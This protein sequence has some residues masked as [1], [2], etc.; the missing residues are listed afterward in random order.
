L[1]STR[2]L[3]I[4]SPKNYPLSFLR[5]FDEFEIKEPLDLKSIYEKQFAANKN[6][7]IEYEK[8][9]HPFTSMIPYLDIPLFPLIEHHSPGNLMFLY[10]H[11]LLENSLLVL[12][13]HPNLGILFIESIKNLL[14]PF[15][16][17]HV[18]IPVVSLRLIH[19]LQ[20]PM[21]FL[22]AMTCPKL[23]TLMDI[24]QEKE[25]DLS[26]QCVILDL[27]NDT[28]YDHK[29][30]KI[31]PLSNST[32]V[33]ANELHM[34]L[35]FMEPKM[36]SILQR[37][38]ANVSVA[39]EAAKN[40]E[41]AQHDSNL[42]K[43]E[44]KCLR[45]NSIRIGRRLRTLI[46]DNS[47][48]VLSYSSPW[49]SVFGLNREIQF[50]FISLLST[51]FQDFEYYLMP[52]ALM[53]NS[54]ENNEHSNGTADNGPGDGTSSEVK[55]T[56]MQDFFD[57]RRY[58]ES[59][60]IF[61]PH[62]PYLSFLQSFYKTQLFH[63]FIQKCEGSFLNK[64]FEDSIFRK[65]CRANVVDYL[66]S[67]VKRFYMPYS[68]KLFKRGQLR[69]NWKSREFV[70]DSGSFVL[71]Y[72]SS[73]GH[74]KGTLSLESDNIGNLAMVAMHNIDSSAPTQYGIEITTLRL[75]KN[76]KLYC[77]TETR[78]MQKMWFE[79][80]QSRAFLSNN[81]FIKL[82]NFYS[83]SVNPSHTVEHTSIYRSRP[84]SDNLSNIASFVSG[85]MGKMLDDVF[86]INRS[87]NSKQLYW[88][89]MLRKLLRQNIDVSSP[90]DKKA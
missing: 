57:I 55:Q 37:G 54:N 80:I 74:L 26:D 13:P 16:W 21:P 6:I 2:S 70:L 34:F 81:Q 85:E 66:S 63:V 27:I 86:N 23:Q 39:K 40:S 7:D 29:F 22:M 25:I 50:I 41:L 28:I 56:S 38:K 36:K 35:E 62:F 49:S 60:H 14:F 64:T 43:T 68:A 69:K 77:C 48:I 42:G 1:N 53:K 45:Q 59:S 88:E 58:L 52:N 31:D 4:L 32:P 30:S 84:K 12:C 47:E 10:R 82:C 46:R 67:I 71:K 19:F 8:E 89:N 3:V 18:E 9:P 90:N 5:L 44:K 83:V 33:I 87:S 24:I 61:D 51:L 75:K 78:E 73:G 76:R 79:A 11:L 17:P 15:N 65:L 20:S 72:F